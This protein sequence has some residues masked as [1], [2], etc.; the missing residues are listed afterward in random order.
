MRPMSSNGGFTLR[1]RLRYRFDNTLARG[2]WA[3]LAWLGI[4]AIAFVL[5][6]AFIVWV[7]GVGPEDQRTSFSDGIWQ[8]LVHS[9]DP[10]TV[11]GAEGA[12]F[13]WVMIIVT[14]LGIFIAA[15]IIGIVS[16]AIDTR[17]DDLR[18]GKSLV[19][20]TGHTLIIGRSDKLPAVVSEIV[21]ANRSESGQAIVVFTPDDGVEVNDEIRAAVSDLGTSRLVVRTGAPTRTSELQRANPE[22]ARSA[23]VLR[24]ND[25][26]DAHVVKA[27]LAL[28]RLVPGLEGL[29]VV[30]EIEDA[31]TAEALR[32]AV[33]PGLVTVVPQPTI[34]R[35]TAQVSRAAG[36]GPVY[37]DL[38]DFEG[39]EVYFQPLGNEW[40]GRNFGELLLGSSTATI[41]GLQDADGS[42]HL[43]PDPRTVI[44]A[45]QSAIGVCEDDSVFRL[46]RSPQ[47][48]QPADTRRWE[49]LDPPVEKQLLLGWSAIAPLII[50]EVDKKVAPGSSLHV[51]IDPSL[52]DIEQVRAEAVA[53]NQSVVIEEGEPTRKA[54]VARALEGGPFDHIMILCEREHFDAHEADA[55][56]LLGLM[57]VRGQ[58]ADTPH[59]ETIVAEVLDP[60]DVELGGTDASSDFIVSQRLISLLMAQ[61][62]QNPHLQHVFS[63]LLDSDGIVLGLHPVSRYVDGPTTTFDDIIASCREWGVVAMGYRAEQPDGAMHVKLNPAKGAAITVGP[64]DSI[65]VLCTNQAA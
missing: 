28:H 31:D 16:S 17:L 18:R 5:V 48:W 60:S 20:E 58:I 12:G 38:L 22:T 4:I 15:A 50:A 35:L 25:E 36:L 52:H 43:N 11:S 26:S 47:A 37:Q 8:A 40:A 45:G 6:F 29:T 44:A 2:M 41:I 65:V 46:D 1:Q 51:L 24:G 53:A 62:S 9:L 7:L 34:A 54:D 27:V 33:G 13:R 32:D 30:A 23:I 10:G 63:D 49:P 39:D 56:T 59:A 61:L 19:V 55:R 21:E 42:V 57:L 14:L 64:N 3:V